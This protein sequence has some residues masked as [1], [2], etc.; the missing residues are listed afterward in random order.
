MSEEWHPR[1]SSELH[2]HVHTWACMP[3]HMSMPIQKKILTSSYSAYNWPLNWLSQKHLLNV[4]YK[5]SNLFEYLF[6]P[7]VSQDEKRLCLYPQKLTHKEKK[8]RVWLKIDPSISSK[9]PGAVSGIPWYWDVLLWVFFFS[10]LFLPPACLLLSQSKLI[11]L[12]LLPNV[13]PKA[14]YCDDQTS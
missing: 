12:Q 14:F 2:T 1:L 3:T 9:H 13:H 6:K 4:W 8:S 5:H 7:W 11:A 10:N